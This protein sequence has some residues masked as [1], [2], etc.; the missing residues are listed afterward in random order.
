[1]IAIKQFSIVGFAF[2]AGSVTFLAPCAY[3]LLPGYVS[4]YLGRTTEGDESPR[5]A[6]GLSTRVRLG[7]ALVVGTLVSLG[8]FG[9]Y[10]LLAVVVAVFGT[11]LLGNVAILELVVGGLLVGLG[12]AMAAGI[13]LP[14]P[15]V[16]LPTRRRSGLNYVGFGVLYAAAAAG[17]TAPVFLAVTAVAFGA[18]SGVGVLTLLAYAA[19][20]ALPLVGVTVATAFGRDALVGRIAGR[21]ELIHRLAGV[22]LVVAG[23]VQLYF[24]LFRFNG[25]SSL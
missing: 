17:C 13:E 5:A 14:T 16:Q 20:L 22:L 2:V 6:G 4:Y 8:V 11:R 23:V 19:G 12:T 24:Y 25:L 9:S 10:G 1:M 7:R 3:P 21:T 15:T 18:S